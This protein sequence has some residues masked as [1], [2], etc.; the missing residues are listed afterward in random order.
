MKN[1]I[2]LISAMAII[3]LISL[4]SMNS[5]PTALAAKE[6]SGTINGTIGDD[7]HKE[8][9]GSTNTTSEESENKP[10]VEE[11]KQKG[12]KKSEKDKKQN[13]APV[14]N[15]NSSS[16][17]I[18]GSTA[19]DL[20]SYFLDEDNYALSYTAIAPPGFS[21]A[22]DGSMLT[23][24]PSGHNFTS[25][26]EITASD[27]EL[28]TSKE[29]ELAVPQRSILARLEYSSGSP[30]DEDDNGIEPATGAI[31]LTVGNS[32]FTWSVDESNLCT[33][34]NVQPADG[35]SA[36]VCHGSEKCCGFV[37]MAPSRD[38]W[39]EVFFSAYG[40]HGAASSNVIGAQVLY[41]DYD[42]GADSPFAEIYYSEWEYLSAGYYFP[43]VDFAD[44]C[45][46]TCSLSD[47]NE[48][49]Y[50]L[51][52]EISD[53]TLNLDT[54]AYS[55]HEE[56]S[57][58]GVYLS[59]K[60]SKGEDS[61]TYSLYKGDSLVTGE[62]VEPDYYDIHAESASG[63]IE[64]LE[65]HGVD[66]T[67]PLSAAI[68][69]DRIEKEIMIGNASIQKG[70]AVDLGQ[71]KFENATLAA[72]ASAN[73]LYKCRQWD[74]E[75]EICFGSWEKI[76]E[77]A[78]GEEYELALEQEAFGF[79]E[80]DSNAATAPGLIK[81]IPN[82]SMAMNSNTTIS[83]AEFFSGIGENTAFSFYEQDN[84]S[85]EFENGTAV[86]SPE[87]EFVG[88]AYTFI[89][90][91]NGNA[92][93]ASNVF[94]VSVAGVQGLELENF[95]MELADEIPNI[96]LYKN[97][98]ITLNL[99][100]HFRNINEA[101]FGY[102]RQGDETEIIF[103]ENIATIAPRRGF[104]GVVHT[105]ITANK[106]GDFIV[107]NVFSVTVLEKQPE[108]ME[109]QLV[110]ITD[111]IA[112]QRLMEYAEVNLKPAFK[113]STISFDKYQITNEVVVVYMAV[114]GK[115]IKWITSLYNFN[116]II[117]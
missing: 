72:I 14:W 25:A 84:L 27:G 99:S 89:T 16:F 110:N 78:A 44:V 50:K 18:K 98:N 116:S 70:Y 10:E 41:V 57:K 55:V 60:D 86:V 103:D 102:Y 9:N 23:L 2:I 11:D 109:G 93:A 8:I 7:T 91:S 100:N 5:L 40:Q 71:L 69:I 46:E 12:E 64:R 105:F 58:V 88:T 108:A 82:I 95:T 94:S 107:S 106:S 83:L 21:A 113:Y 54:I 37:E 35:E 19:I 92:S 30:Y 31:D 96:T 77:L 63:I 20:D 112:R 47:F 115:E 48:T 66:I 24:A 90:A 80:A 3:V 87:K 4:Y 114:D 75:R 59:V 73:S 104:A 111:P 42:L 74:F 61:G 43:F 15:S 33:R 52:F 56:P 51:I 67:K 97:T 34:W 117:G 62:F 53:A 101:A 1:P 32:E 76:K 39:N 65:I 68:G 36:M 79:M 29:I 17:I 81:E 38:K 22:I 13:A 45:V 6:D 85:I 28:S 26:M 49:S